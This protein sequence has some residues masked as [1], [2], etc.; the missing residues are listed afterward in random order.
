MSL[1]DEWEGALPSYGETSGPGEAP[2][3]GDDTGVEA[4]PPRRS[5]D[6]S[7]FSLEPVERHI[8]RYSALS[9]VQSSYHIN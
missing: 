1:L 9:Q 2:A 7:L 5:W 8:A 6:A 4:L 3:A